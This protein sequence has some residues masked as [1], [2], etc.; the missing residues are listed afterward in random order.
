[1]SLEKHRA[2]N[3]NMQSPSPTNT[4]EQITMLF[5]CDSLTSE[6]RCL[7]EIT[8]DLPYTRNA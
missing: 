2:D 5:A 3:Y 8:S 6:L 4:Q 7:A 1:M